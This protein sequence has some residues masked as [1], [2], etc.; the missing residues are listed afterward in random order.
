MRKHRPVTLITGASGGIG[1][2][3]ARTFAKNGHDLVLAARRKERLDHIAADLVRQFGIEAIGIKVDLASPEGAGNLYAELGELGLDVEILV[4]NSGLL[5]EGDFLDL[6]LDRHCQ[7]LDVNARSL[8][9]LTHLFGSDMRSR[10]HGRILNVCSTSAFQPVPGVATYAAS[11]AFVLSLSEALS[12]ENAEYGITVTA[13]CP[14]F[15]ETDMIKKQDGGHMNFPLV[16]LLSAEQVAEEAYSATL[17]GK[18]F[19]ING[20]GNRLMQVIT[21]HSPRWI[22]HRLGKAARKYKKT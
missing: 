7:I 18:A 21:Q 13:V 2:E 8:M 19:F 6:D 5:S 15:V 3:L 17:E 1:E 16:P 12:I 14:G 9:Q 11:K 22:S 20:R 10:E 4:N